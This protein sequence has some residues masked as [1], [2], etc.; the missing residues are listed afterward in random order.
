MPTKKT[1]TAVPEQNGSYYL[2][3]VLQRL[4]LLLAG[5]GTAILWMTLVA[6]ANDF[7]FLGSQNQNNDIANV[8]GLN[9]GVSNMTN[10]LRIWAVLLSLLALVATLLLP[11]FAHV[12]KYEK[13]VVIDGLI[14]SVFLLIISLGA[15][16]IFRSILE[17]STR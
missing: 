5:A 12:R 10:N 2:V 6:T 13:R 17:H 11:K 8:T 7:S 9:T 1:N 4:L 15:L 3:Y 14:V 16:P